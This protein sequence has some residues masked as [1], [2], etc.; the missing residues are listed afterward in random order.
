M[1]YS[2]KTI[3]GTLVAVGVVYFGMLIYPTLEESAAYDAYADGL[4]RDL[5]FSHGSP[6]IRAGDRTIEVLNLFPTSPD[7]PLAKAGLSEGDIV[8]DDF[9]RSVP[10]FYLEMHNARG[11]IFRFRVAD[12]G[13]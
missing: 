5:G 10:R 11:K 4:R 12:G 7:S 3:L 8:F 2:L 13:D 1:V 6:Y 9:R